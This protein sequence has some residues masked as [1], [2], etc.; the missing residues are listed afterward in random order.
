[1]ASARGIGVLGGTRAITFSPFTFGVTFLSRKCFE[2]HHCTKNS[3]LLG[4]V[5]KHTLLQ[6]A[7]TDR[8]P[9]SNSREYFQCCRTFFPSLV[10]RWLSRSIR[11]IAIPV[12][13]AVGERMKERPAGEAQ[14]S[15]STAPTVVGLL[16]SSTASARIVLHY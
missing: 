1:M 9:F 10:G 11:L 12:K 8:K 3:S 14:R 15:F 7:A 13:A 4:S 16:L 6:R 2:V 5:F